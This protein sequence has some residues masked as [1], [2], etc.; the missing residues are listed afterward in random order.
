MKKTIIYSLITSLLLLGCSPQI[1]DILVSEDSFAEQ[2]VANNSLPEEFPSEVKQ[3]ELVEQSFQPDP[4]AFVISF[5]VD[6]FSLTANI[7]V[8]DYETSTKNIYPDYSLDCDGD[9]IFEQKNLRSSTKCIY[10]TLGRHRMQLKGFVPLLTLRDISKNVIIEQWGKIP[11]YTMSSF[12]ALCE[13]LTISAKDA[14]DLSRVRSMSDMFIGSGFNSPIEHWDVSNVEDMNRMFSHAKKFNQPLNGWNVSNVTDMS[15]M[16][17]HAINFN[18]PLNE[19]NVSNVTDMSRMFYYAE[20]FD[21]PLNSW[22]VSNVKKM[23]GMFYEASSFNSPIGNWNVSSVTSFANMFTNATLF[24]QPIGNWKPQKSNMVRMFSGAEH[25]NQ[26]LSQWNFDDKNLRG[27]FLYARSYNHRATLKKI[28][29][30]CEDGSIKEID[31]YDDLFNTPSLTS[32]FTSV[33]PIE[34]PIRA[35]FP[36]HQKIAQNSQAVHKD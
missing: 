35:T 5:V 21:Q 13:Y 20:S 34:Q 36:H 6:P 19:W 29:K 30:G 14:P 22:D 1:P 12:G 26:D 25:F 28:E 7:N 15:R 32:A 9:G 10:T 23:N 27:F 11:W 3:V 18:Q 2:Q 17:S 24:N 4:E 31:S 8:T 16:F 33:E